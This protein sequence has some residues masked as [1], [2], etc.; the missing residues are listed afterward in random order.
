MSSGLTR[1]T[2]W[3]YRERLAQAGKVE[4]L[5]AAFD[6]HL[7][8]QGYLAM[9]GQIIDGEPLERHWSERTMANDR[10]GSQT[11]QQPGRERA[12]QG[13]RDARG[14]GEPAGQAVPE[15]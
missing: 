13:R 4:G 1:G 6:G 5:F 14:L 3:H 15:G 11:V 8:Q 9:G 10:P 7:E 12:D 2:V